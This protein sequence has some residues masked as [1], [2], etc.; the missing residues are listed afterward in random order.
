MTVKET[1]IEQHL[2]K[3]LLD[4]NGLCDKFKSARV[5]VPDRIATWPWGK[6]DF[7]ET[8]STEGERKSWQT[9]DHERRAWRG[10]PVFLLNSIE[11]VNDYV[12]IRLDGREPLHLYS[13]PVRN[14][15]SDL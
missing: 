7:I 10:V 9:R 4:A 6:V 11:K 5:G 15:A 1:P 12:S 8:K 13:V 2:V 14:W 3:R